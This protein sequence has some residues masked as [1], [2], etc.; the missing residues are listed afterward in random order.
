MFH[1]VS[2]RRRALL[3]SISLVVA[4]SSA[5]GQDVS[6]SAPGDGHWIGSWATAPQG[7]VGASS[8]YSNQTLRLIYGATIPPFEGATMP[9][10]FSP[11]GEQK[12]QAINEWIREGR[13]YDGVIDCDRALRDPDHPTRLLPLYD[14]GDHLHPNDAG[15]KAMGDAVPLRL[16]RLDSPG[17]L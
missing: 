1:M 10:F 17:G 9:G 2:V 4:T 3:A 14:S 16:F 6:A 5:S 15:T 12:R 11:E 13:E 8:Q 7:V